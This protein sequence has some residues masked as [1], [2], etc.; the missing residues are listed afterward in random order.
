MNFPFLQQDGDNIQVIK[1]IVHDRFSVDA[2][3]VSFLTGILLSDTIK[4][5]LEGNENLTFAPVYVSLIESWSV[6]L[7]SSSVPWRTICTWTAVALLDRHPEGLC[8][9]TSKFPSLRA[10]Y[11]NLASTVARR[12]WIE[13]SAAPIFSHYLQAL[14]ELYLTVRRATKLCSSSHDIPVT[15]QK[16]LFVDAAAPIPIEFNGEQTNSS[17]DMGMKTLKSD[18]FEPCWEWDESWVES[19]NGWEV[20]LGTVDYLA[21]DWTPPPPSAVRTLT[22][23]GEGPPMLR[24]GCT[25][26]RGVD[27]VAGDEDGKDSYEREKEERDREKTEE[28]ALLAS[29]ENNDDDEK[30]SRSYPL[31]PV[32]KVIS[33]EP[34]NGLAGLARRVRWSRTGAIGVYRFGGDGGRFDVSHVE[35]NKKGTRIIKRY[36]FPETAEQAAVRCGFGTPKRY[37]IILRVRT[38]SA[39][40]ESD[41][42]EVDHMAILEWPDFGAAILASCRFH[43]DGAITITE[44]R[45]IYGSNDSGWEARFGKANFE[46]GTMIVLSP[47]SDA[48]VKENSAGFEELLG[49]ASYLVGRLRNKANGSSVRI[50]FE[51]RII[52]RRSSMKRHVMSAPLPPIQFDR[53]YH[54]QA[55]GISVDGMTAT[56]LNADGRASAFASV[57][58]CK[59]VHFWEVKIEQGE[60]GS[61]FVGVAE[62][63]FSQS[64]ST[65]DIVVDVDQPRLNK[66]SGWGFVNF[67]T[68]YSS[69]VERVYGT[70]CHAGDTIGVLLDCDSGRLSFF[71]DSIKYG[72]H[73]LSD[74]GCAFESLSPFGFTADGYGTGGAGRGSSKAVDSSRNGRFATYGTVRP[75]ALWPVIGLRHNG[76]RVTL[77]GKWMTSYGID[78]VSMLRNACTVDDILSHFYPTTNE[79]RLV[80]V[81]RSSLVSKKTHYD[82]PDSLRSEAYYEYK[83]WQEDRWYRTETRGSGP[84]KLA[85]NNLCIDVDRT[86]YACAM[87]CANIGLGFVLLPGDKVRVKRSAGRILELAEEAVVLGAYQ[88]RLWYRLISQRSDG[89]SLSEGG[90]RAWFWNE[91]EVVS[92]SLIPIGSL[93]QRNIQ[94][95]K[96]SRFNCA[97]PGGLRI[98]YNGGAVMRTDLEIFAESITLGI[99]PCGAIIPQQDIFECRVNSCGVSRFRVKYIPFGEGWISE[100]IRGVKEDLIVEKMPS[101]CIADHVSASPEEAAQIWLESYEDLLRQTGEKT[102]E[103]YGDISIS[104]FETLLHSGLFSTLSEIDSDSII[105]TILNLIAEYADGHV[106]NLSFNEVSSILAASLALHNGVRAPEMLRVSSC[107]NREVVK[108][109]ISTGRETPSLKSIMAR[110]SLL[111]ALNRRVL[112]ALPLIFLQSPQESSSILG[113]ISGLGASIDIKKS[114]E[115][116]SNQELVSIFS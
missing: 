42:S 28:N 113:G 43:Q 90:D 13:R 82:I 112:H 32:G 78:G 35:T 58:F 18:C 31:L 62:K 5:G 8:I 94:L 101:L 89:G 103:K 30:K 106:L 88:G 9:V 26:V 109:L 85:F 100:R 75:K 107:V 23:S 67:R 60:A 4:V 115:K 54:S 76:D 44:K 59:G 38:Y 95:R 96:L 39:S 68:A 63:N 40:S 45:L 36:P 70:H 86:P 21:A 99:I 66:W 29:A 73:I 111:R 81:T 64:S 102:N 22:D 37:N 17:N 57:G 83:R 20:W 34:W 16:K 80:E 77:T 72:E 84:L 108:V 69:G 110:M 41:G 3:L 74:L 52:R 46:P 7:V 55:I 114:G 6:G 92:E 105:T 33:L 79:S 61:I 50:S 11:E 49:S 56:C 15:I 53:F 12:I 93:F 51:M 104:D 71:I 24:E 116:T 19:D 27:W 97:A 98:I 48:N 65:Q 2:R 87:A 47:L 1:I 91:S 25:V 14:F 10:Y